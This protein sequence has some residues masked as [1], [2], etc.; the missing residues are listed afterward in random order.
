MGLVKNGQVQ[1]LL[2]C[3]FSYLQVIQLRFASVCEEAGRTQMQHSGDSLQA[4]EHLQV[5]KSQKLTRKHEQEH[6]T[7]VQ[8]QK[9][10]KHHNERKQWSHKDSVRREVYT[11]YTQGQT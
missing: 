11:V 3:G 8:E 6:E 2:F 5:Q 10:K 9:H 7:E 4:A 1:F